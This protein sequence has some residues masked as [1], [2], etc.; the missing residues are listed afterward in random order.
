MFKK[1][2]KDVLGFALTDCFLKRSDGF[3]INIVRDDG[4]ISASNPEDWLSNKFS[5]ME[6]GMLSVIKTHSRILD[7]G[8]G[9]GK[10]AIYLQE[11]G[12]NVTGIDISGGSIKI[13]KKRGL[14]KAVNTSIWDFH[15]KEDER[16][17]YVTLFGYTIGLAG[18]IK[19]LKQ[20]LSKLKSLLK[21]KG[22]VVLNS[23]DWRNP[24]ENIHQNY[25]KGKIGYKGLVKLRLEYRGKK[26]NWFDWI[27][28]D[29]DILEVI[30][31]NLGMK[32]RI[33]YIKG[34]FFAAQ[35]YNE[36]K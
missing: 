2:E 18:N 27:W 30:S 7:I 14:A 13:A 15:P 24:K 17:D 32:C 29:P 19:G 23:V 11:K 36:L 33:I 1:L 8:C 5:D 12:N 22:S 35:I 3:L 34:R 25:Q 10:H 9:A 4:H 26:G 28:I 31:K 20:I 21:T 16:Y 6:K